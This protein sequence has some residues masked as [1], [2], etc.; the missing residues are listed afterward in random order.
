MKRTIDFV[1]EYYK[2]M[3]PIIFLLVIFIAF[4]TYY[5]ISVHDNHTYDTEENVY[6]YFYDKKYEYQLIVGKNKKGVIK[7]IEPM[8][9]KI[10]M[11][12]TPIYFSKEDTVIFPRDMSVV[13]PT[14]SCAEYLTKG[15]SYITYNKGVYNLV[16]EKYNN[17]LNHYFFYDGN[18][19][20]FFI[21]SVTLHI[22]KDTIK[23]SPYSYIIAH[24]N[25]SLSYYDKSNDI[26]KTIE[27]GNHDIYIENDYY[28]V[29]VDRDIIDYQGTNVILRSDFTGLNTID[30]FKQTIVYFFL[31]ML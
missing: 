31:F 3:L 22:N 9:I 4:I 1:K 26:Y 16:T 25:K 23:L 11:D 27:I 2:I 19:M 5:Q 28:K 13:M 29:L 21:E 8:D 18:D 12:S 30:K 15:I 17:R 10:D 24:Y 7:K 6:Q 14:L 20:Y